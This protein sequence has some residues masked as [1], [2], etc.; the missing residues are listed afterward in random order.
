MRRLVKRVVVAAVATLGIVMS[1]GTAAHAADTVLLL[2]HQYLEQVPSEGM[3]SSTVERNIFLLPGDYGFF[4]WVKPDAHP[5]PGKPCT[6]FTGELAG[7]ANYYWFSQIIPLDG[8]YLLYSGI[9]NLVTGQVRTIQC[10]V[11]LD[12]SGEYDWGSGLDPHF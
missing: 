11:S 6:T 5:V 4:H 7:N 9:R 8:H 1:T 10:Y 2:K 12:H 3:P